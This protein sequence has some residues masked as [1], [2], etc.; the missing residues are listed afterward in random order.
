MPILPVVYNPYPTPTPYARPVAPQPVWQHPAGQRMQVPAAMAE[1]TQPRPKIRLQAPDAPVASASSRLSL[2]SPEALGISIGKRR[3][4]PAEAVDWNHLR[5]RLNQLGALGFH[6]DKLT[7]GGTR[8]RFFLPSGQ[9]NN[10]HHI[11]AAAD[12]EPAA[13]RLALERAETWARTRR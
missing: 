5:A 8:V 2:P 4:A 3:N 9:P 10:T 13:L 11:E 1:R 7:H 6:L 12:T